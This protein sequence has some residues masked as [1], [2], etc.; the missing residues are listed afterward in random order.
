[1]LGIAAGVLGGCGGGG[2]LAPH[3]PV[4]AEFVPEPLGGGSGVPGGMVL[5]VSVRADE[6]TVPT[7]GRGRLLR[8][9]GR[10]M[11]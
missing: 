4:G 10:G 1:M 2:A 8:P 7:G 11:S 9:D 5:V 3:G 6:L